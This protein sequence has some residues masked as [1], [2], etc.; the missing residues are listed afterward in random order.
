MKPKGWPGPRAQGLFLVLLCHK[1]NLRFDPLQCG[2]CPRFLAS[3]TH[4]PSRSIVIESATW[5]CARRASPRDVIVGN[6][7]YLAENEVFFTAGMA[8]RLEPLGHQKP[9][10]CNAQRGVTV[11]AAP[12]PSRCR[13]WCRAGSWG[14]L[15]TNLVVRLLLRQYKAGLERGQPRFERLPGV[16]HG[17][18]HPVAKMLHDHLG[19]GKPVLFG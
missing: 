15:G 13:C 2:Q 4:R 9:V 12:A 17:Q 3:A 16:I 6:G 14:D 7:R 1:C 5:R 11:K 18:Q 8:A 10:G 19:A